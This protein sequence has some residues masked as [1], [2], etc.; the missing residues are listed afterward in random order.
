[1]IPVISA[2]AASTQAQPQPQRKWGHGPYFSVIICTYNRCELALAVVA[3]LYRQTLPYE[4]FEVIV[5]DNG[6]TDN[7]F[8]ALRVYN[9]GLLTTSYQR[10][11]A[12]YLRETRNGQAFARDS[13]LRLARGHIAVFLDDDT[14]ADPHFLEHLLRAYE[15]SGADAISGHVELHWEAQRPY[16]LDDS[17]LDM[18]GYF[19]PARQRISLPSELHLNNCCFS[20]KMSALLDIGLPSFM[21]SKRFNFPAHLATTE[22]SSRLRHKGYELW[23]EP[24][25]LVT[26]RIPAA[27][28]K[29]SFFNG[30][31]YWQA[32]AEVLI[33]HFEGSQESTSFSLSQLL[34]AFWP[35]LR[36]ILSIEIIDLPLISL[37]YRPAYERLLAH[38]VQA[39]TWGDFLQRMEI[40]ERS[41]Q[42][43]TQP[44]VLFIHGSAPQVER[45]VHHVREYSLRCGSDKAMVSASWLWRHRT[46]M[47]QSIALIHIYNPGELQL[48]FFQ[49]LCFLP[50]L[51]LARLLGV[52]VVSTDSG[53]H[54]QYTST[55]RARSRSRFEQ[56]VFAACDAVFSF[57]PHHAQL[58]K[59]GWRFPRI[60]YLPHPGLRGLYPPP[61]ERQ[62]ALEQLGLPATTEFTFLCL[63]N[64]HTER[65]V[66]HLM[67]A[68][69]EMLQDEH[70][71]GGTAGPQ[72]LIVGSP[73]D[74][75]RS[76][77]VLKMAALNSAIHLFLEAGDF[78]EI[79]TQDLPLCIGAA[80]ALVVPHFANAAAGI[81]ETAMLFYSYS[82]VVVAPDLPRFRDVLPDKACLLYNPTER[83]AL[84]Q[85]L[86]QARRHSYTLTE[87]EKRE[88]TV[89][90]AWGHY[91]QQLL[92]IYH[93]LLAGSL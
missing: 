42:D 1:M 88:L 77:R 2:V 22:L 91:T 92:E 15:E 70:L 19:A 25:A 62:R 48:S 40:A 67:A 55:R 64:M 73:G 83:S 79:S 89:E 31:A 59:S 35:V 72:L 46:Y 13:A 84:V 20:V 33:G 12:R 50:L 61:L 93:Q 85:A 75:L 34:R 66:L 16:W 24:E 36:D 56:K 14:L 44:T 60:Y 28:L 68:F 71:A 30:R 38:M 53:G 51:R 69:T 81:C 43:T 82:R 39:R 47:G 8:D 54:W 26:H 76:K 32:R 3:S 29:Q 78:Q 87:Q 11:Q 6:S 80:D 74:R 49:R 90:R 65:E 52:R 57:T 58:H 7:T 18:L 21:L 17:L 45:L 86:R 37:S 5:V 23:Y 9:N 27:R 4:L 41:P 63:A 10:W